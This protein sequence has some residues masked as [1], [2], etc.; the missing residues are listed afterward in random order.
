M[1]GVIMPQQ[2]FNASLIWKIRRKPVDCP[3]LERQRL[4]NV[5]FSQYAGPTKEMP[6]IISAVASKLVQSQVRN[7]LLIN[8]LLCLSAVAIEEE[9]CTAAYYIRLMPELRYLLLLGTMRQEKAQQLLTKLR[10]GGATYS[11][12]IDEFL[13]S[14]DYFQDEL[15][16]CYKVYKYFCHS[17]LNNCDDNGKTPV[18]CR[19]AVEQHLVKLFDLLETVI[20]NTKHLVGKL[21]IW[22]TQLIRQERE[23][24][25]N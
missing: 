25:Y 1:K 4:F 11:E 12:D 5:C 8:T 14:M 23:E 16:D 17:E 24:I 13:E 2:N 9:P 19:S 7:Q 22:Q 6:A 20:V 10:S 3:V 21:E 15:E 18:K